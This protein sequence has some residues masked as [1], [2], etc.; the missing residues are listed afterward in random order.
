MSARPPSSVPVLMANR[1][2]RSSGSLK[3][4]ETYSHGNL[5]ICRESRENWLS[6]N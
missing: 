6:T 4:T 5:W 3:I 2:A 1:K